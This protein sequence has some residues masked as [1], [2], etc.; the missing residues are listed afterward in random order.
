MD[1]TPVLDIKPYVPRFDIR[2][3]ATSGWMTEKL[4]RLESARDDGRFLP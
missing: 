4:D 3:E 1:G 2:T